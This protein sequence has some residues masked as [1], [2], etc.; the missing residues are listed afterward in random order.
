MS[1]GQTMLQDVRSKKCWLN[2]RHGLQAPPAIQVSL[3]G[4]IGSFT[5][6]N[7]SAKLAGGSESRQGG[8]LLTPSFALFDGFAQEIASFVM[9][10]VERHE[11]DRQLSGS[12]ILQ[13]VE[14]RPTVWFHRYDLAV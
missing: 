5:L 14:I 3:E 2:A 13:S 6:H 1:L 8:F 10:A 7:N 4:P 12:V 11:I 9:E